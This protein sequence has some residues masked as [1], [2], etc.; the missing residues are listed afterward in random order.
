VRRVLLA[1]G[2]AA[3]VLAPPAAAHVTTRPTGIEDE[4]T[5]QVVLEV[6]NER[7]AR[8]TTRVELV[9][10]PALAIESVEAPP[11]WTETHDAGRATWSG[12]AI[13]GRDVVEFPVDLHASGRAGSVRLD[14]RQVY[15]DGEQEPWTPSL[16]ILPAGAGAP[17]QRVGRA[18]V[19]SLVGLVVVGGSLVVLHRTRRGRSG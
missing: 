16:E 12:G 9:V 10:P 13:T 1:A 2:A 14:V 11:G 15:D 4:T 6:P 3:A 7:D 19:A 8:T 5:Q 17:K 18:V